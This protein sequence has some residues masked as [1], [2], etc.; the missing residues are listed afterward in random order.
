[1]ENTSD[2]AKASIC[3]SCKHRISRVIEPVLQEDKDYYLDLLGVEDGVD[4]NGEEIDEVML[5]QHR[6]LLLDDDIDGIVHECNRY[7]PDTEFSLLKDYK[8]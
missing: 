2:V 7:T 1:M 4:S 5:E 6:C 3:F 8:F